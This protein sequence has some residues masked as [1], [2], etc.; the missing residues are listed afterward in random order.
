MAKRKYYVLAVNRSGLFEIAYGS[1]D[2][3]DVAFEYDDY[4]IRGEKK[5]NLAL[6]TLPDS[7]QSTIDS[8][9]FKLNGGSNG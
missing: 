9:I 6:I 4:R 3:G 7:E 5:S 8:A 2:R 1:H